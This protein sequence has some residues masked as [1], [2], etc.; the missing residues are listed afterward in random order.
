MKFSNGC[1]LQKEGVQLF[2]PAEAYFITKTDTE[3]T[4]CAPTNRVYNKG[5]TLGGINLTVKV[6]S[7]RKD[8]LRVQ[9]YHHLGAVVKE[10]AFELTM[11]E[12]PL[13]VTE[14]NEK[15]V[16]ES[17]S[18]S[19]VI[20]KEP[21]SMTYLRNGK[22][23]TKSTGKDLAL[24]KTDWKGD[25]YDKGDFVDTYIRQQLSL[26]VGELL[27]GT[28]EHFTPFVKNGQS[29]DIW[30][31]DGGTSTEQAYKNIPFYV[32]N[33]GYGVLVNHPEKVSFELGTEM[34]TRAEFSVE[35]GYLDYFLFGGDSM[36][37]VLVAYTDLTGKPS[38][39]APWTFGLWLSTSFTTSYDEATVM[40]F[41]DGMLERGIPLRTFHFD[42]CWMKEFHW[43]DFVWDERLFPDPEGMLKRI[44]EKGLNI[45]VWI[46]S[47][48]GQESRLFA[49][50]MEKGYFIKRR[51]GRCT[52][53]ICGSRAWPS[54]TLPI[55]RLTHGS[56]KS[57]KCCLIWVWIALRR[58]SASASRWMRCT[59]TAPI[60]R[61]CTIIT[62]IYITNAFTSFWNAS[63][64]KAKR[65]CLPVPQP[66]ED[67]G[68]RYTGAVTAGRTT[69]PWKRACGAD[70]PC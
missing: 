52:S 11:Q 55:R 64:E 63:A 36:K 18:L 9:T 45:C 60:R 61:K 54:W 59:L 57:W 38:L 20:T 8:V 67:S 41:I 28:G 2:A 47:Y 43:S 70:F 16:V 30:N 48:I 68:S 14:D 19:L 56:R 53:G 62:P 23:L 46:N 24:V 10:P 17:G 39:P 7:P 40:S 65:C 49:E 35:G 5:C 44:K 27:Y 33:K 31:E 34:V 25:Y 15:I 13:T 32:S 42:C 1:W 51:T 3:V 69:N 6:S 66:W 12:C 50:G 26:G 22:V 21:W 37:D 29:I 4:I 58:T